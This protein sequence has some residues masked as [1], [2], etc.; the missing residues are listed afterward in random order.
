MFGWAG[1]AHAQF[2]RGSGASP[3]PHY[4]DLVRGGGTAGLLAGFDGQPVFGIEG[5]VVKSVG[6]AGL[7]ISVSGSDSSRA[8]AECGFWLVANIGAGL[9]L[10]L[11]HHSRDVSPMVTGF[12]GI[13]VP[14]SP[15]AYDSHTPSGDNYLYIE[16]YYRPGYD[17]SRGTFY[18][19]GG[20]MFKMA[21]P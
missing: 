11:D 5:S 13:P 9:S 21:F 7:G 8:Y 16:P 2:P 12:L 14:I 15:S 1:E 3:P 4:A 20:L 18:H 19:E 17:L 10:N 6:W